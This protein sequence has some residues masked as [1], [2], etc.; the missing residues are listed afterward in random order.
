MKKKTAQYVLQLTLLLPRTGYNITTLEYMNFKSMVKYNCHTCGDDSKG[1]Y[2]R[3]FTV[4]K[5]SLEEKIE[6]SARTR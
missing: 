1:W 3:G 4:A 6:T 2:R 5:K